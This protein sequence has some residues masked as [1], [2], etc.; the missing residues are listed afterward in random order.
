MKITNKTNY[1]EIKGSNLTSLILIVLWSLIGIMSLSIVSSNPSFTNVITLILISSFNTIT[2]FKSPKL[3]GKVLNLFS[4][5][6]VEIENKKYK[7]KNTMG[8]KT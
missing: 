3:T 7:L 4:D 2:V 8:K 1:L 5:G 6:T